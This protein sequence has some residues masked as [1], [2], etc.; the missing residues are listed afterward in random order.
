MAQAAARRGADRTEALARVGGL[1]FSHL[2]TEPAR[3]C[4]REARDVDLYLR[5]DERLVH[6]PWELCHDG[7]DFL[8]TKARVGRQVIT[9]QAIPPPREAARGRPTGCAS[10]WSPIRPRACRRPPRRSSGSVH[11]LDELPG[12]EVTLLAGAASGA[13][14]SWRR[15]RSHDVVHFAGHSVYDA[16]APARSGWRLADGVLTATELAQLHPPPLV[17]CSRTPAKP[18]PARTVGRP[19]TKGRRSASAAPS[20]SPASPNYVGTFWVVHDDRE[21]GLRHRL[22][23]R[24]SPRAAASA[25]R[26]RRRVTAVAAT[27]G[28][29]AITWASYVHYG[30]PALRPFRLGCA[31]RSRPAPRATRRREPARFDRVARAVRPA[32]PRWAGPPRRPHLVGRDRRADAAGRRARRGPRRHACAWSFLSGPPGIGKTALLD[33]FLARVRG[34]RRRRG[35]R[36]A[37]PSSSTAPARRTCRSSP[38]SGASGRD[39]GGRGLVEAMRRVRAELARP[40]ARP[41]WSRT[42]RDAGGGGAGRERGSA[43]CASWPSSSKWRR[44]SVRWSSCS[45]T[46]TGATARRSRRSHT[47]RG[48]RGRRACC[49][50]ATYR[51]AE[52]MRSEHPL[53]AVM[54]ELAASRRSEEI[55]L[56]PLGAPDGRDAISASASARAS[57]TT[58]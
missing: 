55:R 19:A 54:Q 29:Q 11:L 20:C 52:V 43:C 50:S 7:T 51:P 27:H 26:C 33:A 22:L 10:C 32:R 56:E 15:S 12:V 38:R 17:W 21:P 18:R 46:C 4:L 47:S 2:L 16:E 25:T 23:P 36:R 6:V 58:A 53:R 13:S 31:T 57:S 34:R 37:M 1:V 35:S 24:A 42:S 41:W 44:R 39:A 30:D 28:A 3:R 8:V 5:L 14:R 49:C 45:R 9:A 40:A 48:R